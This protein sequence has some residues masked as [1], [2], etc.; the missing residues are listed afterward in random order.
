MMFADAKHIETDL[1]GE[2]DRLKQLPHV[3]CGL[4]GLIGS[5]ID[6]GGY[7]TV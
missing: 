1:I 5:R 7:K 2:R 4:D 3:P 6:G